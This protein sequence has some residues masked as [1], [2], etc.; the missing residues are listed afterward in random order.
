MISDLSY[1]F[2]PSFFS[3]FQKKTRTFVL[4]FNITATFSPFPACLYLQPR[5]IFFCTSKSFPRTFLFFAGTCRCCRL[6]SLL[7]QFLVGDPGSS[8]LSLHYGSRS[9][10]ASTSRELLRDR[11]GSLISPFFPPPTLRGTCQEVRWRTPPFFTTPPF[12]L[13]RG[14]CFLP[15]TAF[16]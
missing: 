10:F 6:C 14:G 13:F 2:P 4:R 5:K 15:L 16:C 12:R 9:V 8:R 7:P 1:F 3:P 11:I